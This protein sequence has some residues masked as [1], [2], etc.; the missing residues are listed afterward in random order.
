[1]AAFVIVGALNCCRI[2]EI[3]SPRFVLV[4]FAK[5]FLRKCYPKVHEPELLFRVLEEM[6]QAQ[7]WKKV[8]LIPPHPRLPETA[9]SE[10]ESGWQWLEELQLIPFQDE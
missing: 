1:M 9:D 4:R 5:G 7:L 6:Y 2:E 8:A 10:P 3:T